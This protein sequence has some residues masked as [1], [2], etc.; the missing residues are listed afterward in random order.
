MA[1]PSRMGAVRA[2]PADGEAMMELLGSYWACD[3]AF[4][5]LRGERETERRMRSIAGIVTMWLALVLMTMPTAAEVTDR[6]GIPGPID[7][8]GKTFE[9]GWSAE[10]SPNYVKQEYVP[11]GQTVEAYEQM[12]LVEVVGGGVSVKDA[13]ASQWAALDKRKSSDPLVNMEVLQHDATGEVLLDF[14]VSSKDDRG[15]YIVE[16]N[17]YRY[18]PYRSP[19]GARGV[20]L[21]AVSHRAYGNRNAK[22]FL[23]GLKQLRPTRIG[24]MLRAPLPS[25]TK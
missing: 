12:L 19:A 16:W 14:I 7:F 13:V 4:G 5:R 17:A 23:G 25:P 15:E 10:P 6:L 9:L 2:R 1:G 11:A 3:R 8:D 18:A 22:A 24:A 21:F 20:L